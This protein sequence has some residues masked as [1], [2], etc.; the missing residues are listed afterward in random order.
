[1]HSNATYRVQ[2]DQSFPDIR[3][4]RVHSLP[5]KA[6]EWEFVSGGEDF[7]VQFVDIDADVKIAYVDAFPGCP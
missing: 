4:K 5:E 3:V 6:G 1:M 2:V 7:T